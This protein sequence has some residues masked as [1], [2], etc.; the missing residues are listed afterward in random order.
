VFQ[1]DSLSI[2]CEQA[3]KVAQLAE[4]T[5]AAEE[6]IDLREQLDVILRSYITVLERRGVKAP[7]TYRP[8]AE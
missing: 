2:V 1:G 7:F 3:A 8:P 6:A 4:G 5:A